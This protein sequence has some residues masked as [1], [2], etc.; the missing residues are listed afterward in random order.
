MSLLRRTFSSKGCR[1]IGFV[2]VSRRKLNGLSRQGSR[3]RSLRMEPLEDRD[4]LS[5]SVGIGAPVLVAFDDPT[6]AA[7]TTFV[8]HST[9]ADVTATV[10]HTSEVMKMQVHTVNA[11]GSIGT[12]GEMDFLLLDD[13]AP[14]NIAHITSLANSGFYNGL[15]FHRIIQD[16]MIQGGDPTGTGSGGSGP[17]GTKGTVQD[18][19]FNADVRFTS[20]GL[21]ALA[22]SGPDSNDCQFFVTAAPYR[23]GDYQYTIVGKLVAGDDIRQAIANVPVEESNWGEMSQPINAPIID[24]VTVVPDTEYGLVMLKAG[25]A[26]TAGEDATVSVVASDNS[27][28]TMTDADGIAG[29]PSLDVSLATDAPST[30]DRP[31]FVNNVPDVYTTMNQPVSFTIPVEEGDAGVQ[32][33][34]GAAVVSDTNSLTCNAAEDGS[35]S[36]TAT[37]SG[38]IT[39]VYDLIVGVWRDSTDPNSN[40]NYDSQNVAL[41]V[42]PTAPASLSITTAGVEDGGTAHINNDLTF[43]VTG[44]TDGL[45]V[46]IFADGDTTPIG[47]ATASGDSVDIHTTTPLADGLHTFSVKQFVQYDD[48]VVGNRTIPAGDLY[49]DASNSTVTLT[50]NTSSVGY[51]HFVATGQDWATVGA[52]GSTVVATGDFNG[53]GTLD[54]IV[55]DVAT[56]S[57]QLWLN[58]GTGH[59]VDSGQ[60]LGVA[61]GDVVA[62][63]LNGDGSLDLLFGSTVLLND[64]TGHFTDTDQSLDIGSGV[65]LGDVNGDGYLDAAGNSLWL[66]DG[67]GHFTQSSQVIGPPGSH[68]TLADLNNDGYLD[69]FVT[70]STPG[71]DSRGEVWWND[72]AG[73][74][75]DSGQRVGVTGHDA[76]SVVLGDLNGDGLLDAIVG[77]EPI[78]APVGGNTPA[79][80]WLQNANHVFYDSGIAFDSSNITLADVNGDGNLDAIV[81]GSSSVPVPSPPQVFLNDGQGHFTQG[82]TIV[83]CVG[84]ESVVMGDFD[85]NGSTDL[86]CNYRNILQPSGTMVNGSKVMLNL[87]DTASPTVTIDQASSQSDPTNDSPI[88][89]TVVFSEPV[90]DFAAGDVNIGGTAGATT[91]TVTADD[92]YGMQYDVAISGMTGDGTVIASIPAGVIHDFSGNANTASTST[93]NTVLYETTSPTVTI[94]QAASQADPTQSA[95]INYTVVFSEPVTDFTADDVTLW[96]ENVVIPALS[97]PSTIITPGSSLTVVVTGSGTTYNVAVSGMTGAEA[98]FASIPAGVAHD[99]AGNPNLA[100]TSTDNRVVYMQPS[101]IENVVVAEAGAVKNNVLESNEPLKITWEVSSLYAVWKQTVTVDGK[102]MT[103]VNG[104]Y[105]RVYYSCPIGT[106]SAGAHTYTIT[107]TDNYSQTF[108]TTGTFTVSPGVGPTISNVVVA[109]ATAPR[110]G[111]LESNETLVITWAATSSNRIVA[112]SVQI[113]GSIYAPIRGPY[114]GLYYSCSIGTQGVG[115]H[116]YT[117]TTTDSLGASSTSSGTFTVVAP[118]PP[119]ISHV[120]VAEATTP[121]NGSLESD[122]KLVITWAATSSLGIASQ[123]VTID[124]TAIK[125]I[126]GPYGGLF[127]SC[128]IGTWTAG[129]HTYVITATD[130]LGDSSTSSGTFTLIAAPVFPPTIADVVVAEAGL[131]KNGVL[132]SNDP[133]KITWSATGPNRITVQ[134][135]QI[136]GSYYG[137]IRGPYGGMYYSDFIGTQGVGSHSYKITTTD[138]KGVSSTA[139]GTFTVVAPAPP[140]IADVVVAEA[141]ATKNGVLESTDPLK[142][143]WSATSQIDVATQTLMIDGTAVTPI[144]GPY[145]G[146]YYSCPIG[147]WAAGSHAY[148][149]TATDSLGDSSTASGTFVVVDPGTLAIVGGGGGTLNVVGTLQPVTINTMPFDVGTV[150][151]GTGALVLNGNA[152]TVNGSVT[153]GSVVYTGGSY[154]GVL[155]VSV[156]TLTV[157]LTPPSP[158]DVTVI[159]INAG[160]ITISGDAPVVQLNGGLCLGNLNGVAVVEAGNATN[161]IPE[162]NEDLAVTWNVPNV[163]AITMQ[164]VTVDGHV[165]TA[166]EGT[167]GG[168]YRCD[169]GGWTAGAHT[170]AIQMTSATGN[171]IFTGTFSVAAPLTVDASTAAATPADLITDAQL[172]PIVAAAKARWSAPGSSQVDSALANIEFKVANLPS[173]VLSEKWQNTIWIDDDAAGYGW[174]VDPTPGDDAEFAAVAGTSSLTAPADTAAAQHADLLTAV[175][176]EMGQVLGNSDTMADDLTNAMLSLGTRRIP[177]NPV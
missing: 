85:G 17:N 36:A 102:V 93:D 12:S 105:G 40:T 64:G 107:A 127:Y 6:A 70:I 144:N 8:A 20:S 150:T 72:G 50:V 66:N 109:E 120:V 59:F 41:F 173:G 98:V 51:A 155:P 62:G 89:F 145:G 169:I 142:I 141:G 106:W 123:T 44:V 46:A 74:F 171:Q 135:L 35:A 170:F 33:T 78:P 48:T 112:Q 177:D 133:L 143:T 91:A 97:T 162:P 96:T 146:R 117:I 75:S 21:L 22:N 172:A 139:A 71:A 1:S 158:G 30:G 99:A 175:M 26:A 152:G 167:D 11:D 90:T 108:S 45:T 163:N 42:C 134:S 4:L 15:T 61:N 9:N 114:G 67:T 111:W 168:G 160:S 88:H 95:P 165:F 24:S 63:D 116:S 138:S 57:C 161:G 25:P 53:D 129:S 86:I 113:D 60:N 3:A 73:N 81:L 104:P 76:S 18:D 2:N 79:E 159:P 154:T 110:N 32:L 137:P 124:G 121:R 10:L 174:F 100:S 7:G 23:D 103:P 29:Q 148:T 166:I 132:E 58:D 37:P 77:D 56:G 151:L 27:T 87:P 13:Y 164:A 101:T 55:R 28:V 136:D 156:G 34:Y 82:E 94:N 118:A 122:E 47:I 147:T 43:H 5:V 14:N 140:A 153:Y 69:I 65:S 115:S 92:P 149:I 131:T 16:F 83:D 84:A 130:S 119:V 125:P 38:D 31:A 157:N 176:H 39:G 80:V 54:V 49:G 128:Q 52:D 19:E 68:L 126:N